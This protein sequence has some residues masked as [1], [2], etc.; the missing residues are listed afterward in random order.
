MAKDEGA[1][2]SDA[3]RLLM[4][5]QAERWKTADAT[6]SKNG[7]RAGKPAKHDR[8]IRRLLERAEVESRERKRIR[9]VLEAVDTWAAPI[10]Q[11]AAC[12]AGCSHCC[13]IPV[14]I[15]AEEAKLLASVTGRAMEMPANAKRIDELEPEVQK[16]DPGPCPFL[17]DG[18]CS[19]YEDRPLIC[20]AHFNLDSDDLL[21]RLVPGRS[22]RVPYADNRLIMGFGMRALGSPVLADIRDFFPG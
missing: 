16:T 9:L 8:Q 18:R 13:H 11:V 21:C 10:E 1:M 6:A 20:R 2:L 14:M 19:V 7:A 3:D 22:T 17:E 5:A 15:S 4:E 12:K